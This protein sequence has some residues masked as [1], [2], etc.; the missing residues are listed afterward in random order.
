MRKVEKVQLVCKPQVCSA[1]S[2]NSA[3]Q[4]AGFRQSAFRFLLAPV[5]IT[6]DAVA[7]VSLEAQQP[8]GICRLIFG[9][10]HQ[11][12]NTLE[13]RILGSDES[14]S[15]NRTHITG[16]GH[17]D[18]DV[19]KRPADVQ[20]KAALHQAWQGTVVGPGVSVPAPLVSEHWQEPCRV[21]PSQ[22]S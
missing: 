19:L 6:E 16:S 3:R 8:S 20:L 1:C 21:R 18:A 17:Q 2:W 11:V 14:R 10:L 12:P 9:R 4:K 5:N 7:D 15:M 13:R 22:A